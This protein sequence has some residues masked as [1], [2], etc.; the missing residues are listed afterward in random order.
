MPFGYDESDLDQDS[1]VLNITDQLAEI[2]AARP[3]T[4]GGR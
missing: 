3:D 4:S 1:F 2:S